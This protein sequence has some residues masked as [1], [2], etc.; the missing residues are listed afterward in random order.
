VKE[1]PTS[2]LR[3]LTATVSPRTGHAHSSEQRCTSRPRRGEEHGH[4]ESSGERAAERGSLNSLYRGGPIWP[5]LLGRHAAARQNCD[6]A[7][8]PA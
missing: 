5:H 2:R 4:P 6:D 3:S 8:T 7:N 1:L